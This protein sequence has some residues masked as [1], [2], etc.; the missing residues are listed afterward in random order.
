M[1]KKLEAPSTRSRSKKQ[2][3]RIARDLK[4]YA[5][6][7]SGATFGENDVIAD[8]CEVEAKVTGRASYSITIKDWLK[9]VTKC[10]VDKM[11]IFMIEF[12]DPNL[13]LAIISKT[14][15]MYLIEAANER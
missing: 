11:P 6:I 5:T 13:E 3:S 15:L 10:K 12:E 14:D 8:F 9:M 4:G 7:N 2:E 1:T